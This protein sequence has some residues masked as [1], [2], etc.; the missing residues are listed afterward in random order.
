MSLFDLITSAYAKVA[1]P[2]TTFFDLK[3]RAYQFD[4]LLKEVEQA[5]VY[6][7]YTKDFVR[8]LIDSPQSPLCTLPAAVDAINTFQATFFEYFVEPNRV[9]AAQVVASPTW[10]RSELR[11]AMA[12]L[13]LHMWDVQYELDGYELLLLDRSGG[14]PGGPEVGQDRLQSKREQCE[15]FR[16]SL[17]KQQWDLCPHCGDR[18]DFQTRVENFYSQQ[19]NPPGGTREYK[20]LVARMHAFPKP[21]GASASP[22]ARPVARPISDVDTP[23]DEQGQTV[24]GATPPG[25]IPLGPVEDFFGD[26]GVQGEEEQE[27]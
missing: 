8:K 22:D 25:G 20:S 26:Q 18:S 3:E 10:Y 17:T 24:F 13:E 7:T 15:R 5:K 12:D 6:L 27:Y 2:I 21:I 19:T 14:A 11:N 16:E 23:E 1:F 9:N 4:E